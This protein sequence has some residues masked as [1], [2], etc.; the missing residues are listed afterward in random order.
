MTMG[1]KVYINI[2]YISSLQISKT[3]GIQPSKVIVNPLKKK[4]HNTSSP[5]KVLPFASFP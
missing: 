3:A 2:C 1:E 4:G 5:K